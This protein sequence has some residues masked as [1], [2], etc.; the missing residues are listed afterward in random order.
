MGPPFFT[1][2]IQGIAMSRLRHLGASM[3]PPFFTAEISRGVARAP[4]SRHRFNGAAVLHGG[5]L[6]WWTGE[7][8]EEPC[9]NGAAVLHGGDLSAIGDQIALQSAS[10]G[11]PFF[12][13]EIS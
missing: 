13:A 1:A 9:F 5:D 11:P 6:A 2:E 3:G 10:M 8:F 7:R 12:T 4:R